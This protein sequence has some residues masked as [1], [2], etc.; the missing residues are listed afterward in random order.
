M[1]IYG[2]ESV[3]FERAS[4]VSIVG[5]TVCDPRTVFLVYIGGHVSALFN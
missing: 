5:Q 4:S 3:L 2:V 1:N